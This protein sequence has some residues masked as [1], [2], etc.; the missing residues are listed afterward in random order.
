MQTA[1]MPGRTSLSGAFI[2]FII[3]LLMGSVFGVAAFTSIAIVPILA[4]LL[5]AGIVLL[6]RPMLACYVL[7]AVIALTSAMPRGAI[8][9]MLAPNELMLLA[10]VAIVG[11][12]ILVRRKEKPL[13]GAILFG[14]GALILTTVIVPILAFSIMGHSFSVM[15]I[16]KLAAPIQYLLLFWAF[17]NMP[18]TDEERRSV[19]QF[20]FLCASI[21]SVIGLLQAAGVPFVTSFLSEWYPSEHTERANSFGSGRITSVFAAWNVLGTFLVMN[22][23]LLVAFKNEDDADMPRLYQINMAVSAVLSITAL[24]GSGSYASIVG[25]LIGVFIVKVFD[26]RGLDKLVPMFFVAIVA[27]FI[28]SPLIAERFAYQFER[29]ESGWLPQTLEFRFEVWRDIYIPLILDDPI[30]GVAPTMSN[31]NWEH[32]ESQYIMTAFQSGFVGVIGFFTWLGTLLLWLVSI[33]Q[34]KLNTMRSIAIAVFA[35]LVVLTIMGI[36][37]PVFTYSGVIDYM[38]ILLGLIASKQ[39]DKFHVAY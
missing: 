27:G 25:L 13:A 6:T 22:L 28:L 5:I 4:V 10:T 14:A 8:I 20:M 18:R 32:P 12:Q 30:W 37:N 38:W 16:F 19:L 17:S 7:I 29:S 36:T 39:K 11:L 9:P 24:L 26:P 2:N 31:L 15:T 3:L 33:I 23:L 1:M 21:V 34:G 35:M